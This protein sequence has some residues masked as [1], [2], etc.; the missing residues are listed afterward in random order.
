MVALPAALWPGSP[1]RSDREGPDA[2]LARPPSGRAHS[3]TRY[4]AG[5]KFTFRSAFDVAAKKSITLAD[6]TTKE[7]DVCAWAASVR[8]ASDSGVTVTRERQASGNRSILPMV[9]SRRS[10][11][12]ARTAPR[13]AHTISPSACSS[14]RRSGLREAKG[15][16]PFSSAACRSRPGALAPDSG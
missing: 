10:G 7:L 1:T 4:G 12:G 3:F 8:A 2:V 5:R 13:S 11:A 14:G 9:G 15:Q 6:E 16:R